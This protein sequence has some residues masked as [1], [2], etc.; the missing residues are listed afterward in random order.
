MLRS[1]IT[2]KKHLSVCFGTE[3]V[4]LVVRGVI[5]VPQCESYWWAVRPLHSR[6]GSPFP[7]ANPELRTIPRI[8]RQHSNHISKTKKQ[9]DLRP[10]RSHNQPEGR[11]AFPLQIESGRLWG[12]LLERYRPQKTPSKFLLFQTAPC[13]RSHYVATSHYCIPYGYTA[14]SL[15]EKESFRHYNTTVQNK[16]HIYITYTQLLWLLPRESFH[17]SR[18]QEHTTVRKVKG[19]F[20]DA[21]QLW[22]VESKSL[23]YPPIHF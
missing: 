6:R 21:I 16:A 12:L 23:K 2:T 10:Q 14:S 3:Y 4:C 20:P 1:R 15:Q 22:R 5:L 17:C 13:S 18:F 19:H 9:T 8:C 11:E 7:K